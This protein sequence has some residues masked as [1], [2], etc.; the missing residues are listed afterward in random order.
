MI[1]GISFYQYLLVFN[2]PPNAKRR[3]ICLHLLTSY[4]M[5]ILSA[6]IL[7][8]DIVFTTKHV[9]E[10]IRLFATAAAFLREMT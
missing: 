5:A 2:I 9:I 7:T 1:V 10:G 6:I 4:L 8:G 3:D